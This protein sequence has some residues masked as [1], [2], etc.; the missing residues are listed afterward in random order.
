MR[1]LWSC[2]I[3]G[4]ALIP[5]LAVAHGPSR[6]K[7]TESIDLAAPPA[8]VWGLIKDFCSIATWHPKVAKCDSAGGTAEGTKRT[9]TLKADSNPQIEE[10]LMNYDEANMTF[11]Y[12]ITKNDVKVLPV[13]GYTSFMT[14][15]T[16]DK[17]G[18]TLSWNGGF[19][20]GYPN[21]NPP[22]EL[23]DEAAIK[24]V[25]DIYKSGLESLK[26]LAETP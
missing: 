17:N 5:M 8:K 21:N 25:T 16:N 13:T 1:R 18:T 6:Q 9:L 23:N 24:A 2:L 15:K 22:P 10:E 4:L 20:R 19:Y 26:K 3:I 14:V 7:V 12:K 11:K